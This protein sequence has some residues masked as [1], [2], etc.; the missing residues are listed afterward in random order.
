MSI[1]FRRIT[2][3]L[4]VT[5]VLV[6]TS[7]LVVGAGFARAQDGTPTPTIVAESVSAVETP[8]TV[9]APTIV[10]EAV[11]AVEAPATVPTPPS[12]EDLRARADYVSPDGRYVKIGPVEISTTGVVTRAEVD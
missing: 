1:L 10:A 2:I 8:A 4:L 11:S 6:A 3:S 12:M 5:L 7:L 9:P